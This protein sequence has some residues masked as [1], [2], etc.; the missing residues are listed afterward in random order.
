MRTNTPDRKL[1][2]QEMDAFGAELDALRERTVADLGEKDARYIR[3]I[4]RAV[5]YTEIAGRGLLFA[6]LFPPAWVAGT[7]LLGISKIIENMELGHNVMHGQYNWM[8][9]PHLDGNTYE[10]DTAGTGDNWRYTHNYMHHTY[11]N[12]MGKDHDVG[13]GLLRLFPEQKW[14]PRYLMNVPFAILLAVFFEWFVAVQRLELERLHGARNAEERRREWA[15][16]KQE[17]KPVGKKMKKQVLKDYILFPL[18]AGPFFLPVLA[19]NAVA[20]IIRNLWAYTIIFCGHFTADAEVFPLESLNDESRGHWYLRQLRGSSNLTGGKLMHIMSGNLSHQ[21]EHHLYPDI[22]ARR[23]A[24]MSVEVRAICKRYGQ[25]YN[26]GSLWSQ[27]GSVVARI[28]RHALP[29]RPAA[30]GA[31]LPAFG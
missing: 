9:D 18:L 5:R 13:Y 10:W 25:H 29:S 30:Q 19:G 26:S 24:E 1:S 21:I 31:Q 7:A 17:F 22:P 3:N 6:G 23:Y 2:K 16:I 28:V 20:N 27:F 11:T 8:R 12:V 15:R 4:E 14:E